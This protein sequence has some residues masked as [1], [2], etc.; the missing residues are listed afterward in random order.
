LADSLETN[1]DAGAQAKRIFGAHGKIKATVD[2]WDDQTDVYALAL[3]AGQ[4][5][6]AV[7]SGPAR[8][9]HDLSLWQPGTQSIAGLADQHLRLTHSPRRIAYAV[10]RG[11]GGVY[12]MAVKITEPGA[13]RYA[14]AFSKR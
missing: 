13:G 6:T 8:T 1:D 10:P 5:L 11:K 2:F 7:L 12:Y 3:R 9:A 4:R 14:L